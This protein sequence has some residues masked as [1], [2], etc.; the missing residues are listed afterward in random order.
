[1]PGNKKSRAVTPSNKKS[2][3]VMLSNKKSR[4]VMP[5]NKSLEL[6]RLVI[7]SFTDDFTAGKQDAV[8]LRTPVATI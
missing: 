1:M 7:R 4:A 5:S 2:R 6:S 8:G 3:A